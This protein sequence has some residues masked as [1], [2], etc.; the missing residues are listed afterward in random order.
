MSTARALVVV[1]LAAAFVRAQEKVAFV[2]KDGQPLT[3]TLVLPREAPKGGVLLLPARGSNRFAFD[4]LVQRLRGSGL[5]LL[6]LDPRGHGDSAKDKD[7]K[8]VEI[9]KDAPKGEKS[10]FALALNDAEAALE[11]LASKGAPAA[12]LAVVAAGC[13][14]ATALGLAATAQDRP[15]ALVLLTPDVEDT[16]LSLVAPAA[17]VARRPVLVLS[18][19]EDRPRGAA[20]LK[21]ALTFE[22]AEFRAVEGTLVRGTAMFGKVPGIEATLAQWIVDALDQPAPLLPGLAPTVVL[23]GDPT[24]LEASDAAVVKVPLG[25]AGE[26]LVRVARADQKLY[27]AFDVP[28]RYLRLNEAVVYVDASG[29]GAALARRAVLPRVVQPE[30][31]GP[32]ASAR[33]AR[34]AEGLRG[35]RRQGRRRDGPHRRQE[36]LDGRDDARPRPLLRRRGAAHRAHGV[37]SQRP[38]RRRQALLARRRDGAD[39]AA[40]VGEGPAEVGGPPTRRDSRPVRFGG[41][42]RP[43]SNGARRHFSVG[44]GPRIVAVDAPRRSPVHGPERSSVTRTAPLGARAPSP[45]NP[46]RR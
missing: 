9:G 24:A 18:S 10:P 34:R 33:A 42:G 14:A 8:P 31:P 28:E 2:A 1:V 15:K 39:V 37:R 38:P 19:E 26:A 22:E 36:A 40:H 44:S 21:D 20:A 17:R 25:A 13:S 7:G 5:A 16:G 11:F 43:R 3:G 4:P 45:A 30:E 12:R 23:D 46:D 41:R 32:Q 6:A 35:Q 29:A 27:V